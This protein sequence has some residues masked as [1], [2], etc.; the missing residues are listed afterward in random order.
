MAP[1]TRF[2]ANTKHI[3]SALMAEYYVQRAN[4][5]LIIADATMAIKG[6]SSFWTEPGIYS[7]DQ[8]IGWKQ[9]TD[10]A[11]AANGKIFLQL[12]HGGRACDPLL[13]LGAQPVGPSPIPITGD[14]VHS[15]EVKKSYVVPRELRDDELPDIITGFKK[16]T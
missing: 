1:L 6:N 14:E 3:P 5:G 10:S 12:W 15:P 11:N 8:I 16:A 2:R 13:N 7:Y 4:A 9:T